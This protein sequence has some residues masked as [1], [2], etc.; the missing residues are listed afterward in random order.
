MWAALCS[1][2][3]WRRKKITHMPKKKKKTNPKQNP[4][5]WK[6]LSGWGL[7]QLLRICKYLKAVLA[8]TAYCKYFDR[9][10]N[11]CLG[12]FGFGPAHVVNLFF[13]LCFKLRIPRHLQTKHRRHASW[14]LIV[15]SGLVTGKP[16]YSKTAPMESVR[17]VC[18]LIL[19]NM[20]QTVLL[21]LKRLF[22]VILAVLNAPTALHLFSGHL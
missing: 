12:V 13:L 1:N 18:Q 5:H 6:P 7:L 15:C 17:A 22:F 11:L 4:P 19:I 16:D 21:R 14:P 3:L 9:V 8:Y 10:G 2:E 20:F